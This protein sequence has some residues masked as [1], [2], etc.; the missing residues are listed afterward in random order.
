MTWVKRTSL[1]LLLLS[2]FATTAFGLRIDLKPKAKVRGEMITLGDV[3]TIRPDSSEAR[4][5]AG[6][7][8]LRAPDPGER[9]VLSAEAIRSYFSR[10][11]AQMD[12]CSWG[13][14]GQVAVERVG[15]TIGPD[16]IR[17]YLDQFIHEKQNLLPQAEIRFKNLSLPL[18]FVLPKGK[19]RV[20][21]VPSDPGILH[22][23]RFTL[24][25]RVDGRVE[26][27]I[28]VGAELEAIAPVVV[29][30]GDLRRG[31]ILRP[32]DVNL[33]KLD[34]STLHDPCFSLKS[35]IGKKLQRSVRLGRPFHGRDVVAP[36][37]VRR[38]QLVT[39]TARKGSLCVTARGIARQNGAQG[40]MIKVLNSTSRKEILCQVSAPGRVKVEF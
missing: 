13:G 10:N 33:A 37:V 17:H 9:T 27:N 2:V 20:E 7:A 23:R 19:L 39:I 36:A 1:T 32:R 14:A 3:A 28:A 25:F 31:R 22:S 6:Q 30:A 15:I 40:A 24:I 5:L 38:G 34:L 21:V 18:P 4:Q 26:K 11:H 16:A 12:R 35:V 8:L 29:A